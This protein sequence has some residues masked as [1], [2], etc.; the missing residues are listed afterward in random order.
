[1]FG[2]IL[3]FGCGIEE[4][5]WLQIEQLWACNMTCTPLSTPLPFLSFLMFLSWRMV[6]TYRAVCFLQVSV[7]V[8]KMEWTQERVLIFIK[9]YNREEII[10]DP[11]HPLHFNKIKKQDAREELAKEINS[12]V[13]ECKKKIW[14]IFS[15]LRLGQMRMKHWNR[16]TWV[17]WTEI[18]TDVLGPCICCV[19]RW[20][21]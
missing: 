7:I 13:D 12:S 1:L 18:C 19:M 8:L 9:G 17:L 2:T 4:M 3:V 10:W 11:Q 6:Q 21:N 5:L 16:K 20:N 15:S 14:N